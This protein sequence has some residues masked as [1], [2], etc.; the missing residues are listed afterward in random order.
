MLKPPLPPPPPRLCANTAWRAGALPYRHRWRCTP[1]PRH[2]CWRVPARATHTE[3][4]L[5]RLAQAAGDTEPAIAAAAASTLRK[6]AVGVLAR[7]GDGSGD[8]LLQR[9]DADGTGT[10]AALAR[11]TQ[12]GIDRRIGGIGGEEGACDT[13]GAVAAAARPRIAP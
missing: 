4:H 13:E 8:H 9:A 3:G 5:R 11:A 2:R 12:G 6:D 1:G 7:G 10:A